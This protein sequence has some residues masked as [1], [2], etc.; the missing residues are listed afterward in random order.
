MNK[1]TQFKAWYRKELCDKY[2]WRIKYIWNLES[3]LEK[4]P[5]NANTFDWDIGSVF[6]WTQP[7][8]FNKEKVNLDIPDMTAIYLSISNKNFISAR[9]NLVK[10]NKN[11]N[12]LYEKENAFDFIE[13][14]T[15]SIVF[16]ISSLEV[17]FNQL[18]LNKDRDVVFLTKKEKNWEEKD[19]KVHDIE[20]LSLEDKILKVLPLMFNLKDLKLDKISSKLID[21]IKMR[22]D[23]IHLKSKDLQPHSE[24]TKQ[25]T[26]WKRIFD[27]SKSNPAM[28][29]VEIIKFFYDNSWLELP[30]F[31]RLIPFK[32]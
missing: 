24:I 10:Y 16:A 28:I 31:L 21:L 15:V 5:W 18:L 22:N 32:K 26:I 30:R 14:M 11:K 20:W 19:L 9:E 12:T 29:S 7:F 8:L 17:F 3:K 23:I 27:K 13:N 25:S 2:D 4:V 1:Q 6:F